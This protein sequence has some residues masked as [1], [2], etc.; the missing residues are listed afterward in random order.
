V[1]L[2]AQALELDHPL[3]SERL[4]FEAPYPPDFAGALRQ[5]RRYTAL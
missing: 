3:R 5:L 1:G 4:R 2:H